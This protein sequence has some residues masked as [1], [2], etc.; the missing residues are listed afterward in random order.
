MRKLVL[1]FL[2]VSIYGAVAAQ[3][4]VVNFTATPLSGCAPLVVTFTDQSTGNPTNWDWD[5]GNGQLSTARN[6]VVNYNQPGVYTVKLVVRNATGIAAFTRTDYITVHPTPSAAFSASTTTGCAPNTV[7]FTDLSNAPGG[8]ITRWEWNFG[9]GQT[10]SAQNPAHVYQAP[11]FYDV[12]LKVTSN[13]GCVATNVRQRYMRIVPGVVANFR[14]I[15]ANTCES[16]FSLSYNNESSGPGN[17]SY[18]WDLGNGTSSN[19]PNASATYQAPGSYGVTLITTSDY[20]CADTVS[21]TMNLS[22]NI[23]QFNAPDTACLNVG[24]NFTNTSNPAPV[25][26]RWDFGDGDLSSSQSPSHTY[27]QAGVYTVKLIN[28]YGNC[29]DSVT[30]QITVGAKPVVDFSALNSASCKAP[31]SVE[32]RDLTAN[33]TAWRWDF[34]DGTTSTEKNPTHLYTNLGEYDISLTATFNGGCQNTI[35]KPIFIQVLEPVVAIQDMPKGGCIPYTFTPVSGVQ[36]VDGVAN[37]LW[38]FGDGTTSTSATPTHTYTVAGNYDIK[39]RITTNTGCTEEITYPQGIKTGT[40]VV[41]DFTADKFD[42]CASDPVTFTDLTV[43]ADEWL[44]DFGD[45]I[46]STLRHPTHIFQDTGFVSVT[47]TAFSNRCPTSIVKP[48]F[49]KLKAPIARFRYTVDCTDKLMVN[50][51][52]SSIID[53]LAGAAT[54]SWVFGTGAATSAQKDPSFKFPGFGSHPVTLTVTNGGCSYTVTRE[55][56]LTDEKANFSSSKT[57]VCKDELFTLTANPVVPGNIKFYEWTIGNDLPITDTNLSI[58]YKIAD[59]GEYNVRLVITDTNFCQETLTLNN[60][61]K[62]VGPDADFAPDAK[63]TCPNT[64]LQFTDKSVSASAIVKWSWDYGD[65]TLVNYTRPPFNHRYSKTGVYSV[66]LSVTDAMGCTDSKLIEDTVIVTSPTAGFFADTIYCPGVNL[67]FND[68]SSGRNLSYLWNFGNGNNSTLQN[69][70]NMYTGADAS[71]NVS[72]KVTDEFGCADSISKPAYIKVRAPKAAFTSADTT[73]LCPPMEARFSFAGQNYKSYY[74]D[75]G[76]GSSPSTVPNPRHFYNGFSV[77]TVKLFT[78]GFGGCLDSA[79]HHVTVSDPNSTRINYSPL[80]A[81][82]SLEVDFDLKPPPYSRYVFYY[83][84]GTTNVSQDTAFTHFYRGPAF[85]LPS[86]FLTDS[87]GCQISLNAGPEIRAIGAKP[88]FGTDKKQFCDTGNVVFT[89]FTLFNDPV[90]SYNWSFG[91]GSVSNAYEPTHFY[92]QPGINLVTLKVQTQRGC[93]DSLTDTIRA[94]RTPVASIVI[95]DTVC[96]NTPLLI[97]GRLAVQDTTRVS[98]QW[99]L[100]NGQTSN[101]QNPGQMYSAVGDYVINLKTSVAFGCNSTVSKNIYVPPAPTVKI[102]GNTEIISGSGTVIPAEY[103]GEIVDYKWTPPQRLNC[104]DC[105]TPYANPIKTTKYSITATDRYGCVASTDI[106]I[107]VVCA[108]RNLFIPNTF[109]PNGDG[110]NDVFYPRGTGV[111]AVKSIKVFNRWG[112]TVFEKM[113]V[114]ANDMSAG[115]NGL[116]KGQKAPQD[117]YVYT[118][119]IVCENSEITTFKGNVTLIR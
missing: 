118:M 50:F 40:P 115:W 113:N 26:S 2:W 65:G 83:G 20:G 119:E 36:A 70:F 21:K 75:F 68:T 32:F 82:N 58:S 109:S 16:P 66:K 87:T 43:G 47:L 13:F 107:F 45:G 25:S 78:E 38:D 96:I 6:P 73:S 14:T 114:N 41:P 90:V 57:T 64:V 23:T 48:N 59:A 92:A 104:T 29:I 110:T 101:V 76:D 88:L 102:N 8:S 67:A 117:T 27:D 94:F 19:Q 106:T 9:D 34:G 95:P 63:G 74:W 60:Y 93:T 72:L 52:D 46:N 18:A 44:W 84:D 91:D 4:P 108:D 1:L 30:R 55:I 24:V 98:W 86:I 53:P 42:V 100:G 5:L 54:Y 7:R 35:T 77:Y 49:I 79:I 33:A 56:F 28:N 112:E 81:C 22:N 62:V 10:S 89:N 37:Y 3:N 103:T 80:E 39:L 105:P 85:F 31:F 12:T 99:S 111:F 116:Y 97:G 15:S 51:R 11:G 71:Y 61:I 69:P 17:L